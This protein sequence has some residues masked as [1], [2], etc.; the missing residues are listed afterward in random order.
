MEQLVSRK[1]V[2]FMPIGQRPLMSFTITNNLLALSIRATDLGISPHATTTTT[3]NNSENLEDGS[4]GM[5]HL[6]I[7]S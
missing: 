4:Y 5:K 7:C 2:L 1:N 3:R 6:D